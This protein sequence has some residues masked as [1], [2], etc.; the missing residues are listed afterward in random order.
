MKNLTNLIGNY[1][2]FFLGNSDLRSSH[3][4]Y[5]IYSP[6]LD[7]KTQCPLLSLR[8]V[9]EKTTDNPELPTGS[10]LDIAKVCTGDKGITSK[11]ALRFIEQIMRRERAKVIVEGKENNLP[12][13]EP[14]E[15]NSAQ[16]SL[17]T[18]LR[19]SLRWKTYRFSKGKFIDILWTKTEFLLCEICEDE[20][21]SWLEPRALF[22]NTD[23]CLKNGIEPTKEAKETI[24]SNT[25][26]N[27][28]ETGLNVPEINRFIR[29]IEWFSFTRKP[30]ISQNTKKD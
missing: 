9:S 7:E 6:G 13:I 4:L 20:T 2:P 17:I 26:W 11:S 3:Y 5:Q 18:N 12:S 22:K 19:D 15:N 25:K 23:T 29:N 1:Y 24:N 28:V 30:I 27:K 16:R 21:G 14:T 10:D 8:K